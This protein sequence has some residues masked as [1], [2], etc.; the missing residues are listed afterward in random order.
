MPHIFSRVS[1]VG[2][3]G[4]DQTK[5]KLQFHVQ[6]DSRQK[7]C[8]S[9]LET[10]LRQFTGICCQPEAR[11]T[12]SAAVTPRPL[13]SSPVTSTSL[14]S[15]PASR[16]HKAAYCQTDNEETDVTELKVAGLSAVQYRLSLSAYHHF[17][18]LERFLG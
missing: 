11:S 10:G 6:I 18:L 17:R 13:Q 15:Q 9:S 3:N 1:V 14:H 5:E 12:P 8:S 2:V 4:C 7:L 16:Q